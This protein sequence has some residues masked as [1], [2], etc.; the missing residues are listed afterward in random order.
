MRTTLGPLPFPDADRMVT[1]RE[2]HSNGAGRGSVSMPHFRDR[3]ATAAA[4][5]D[6]IQV[7]RRK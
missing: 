6:P 3:R 1:I 2:T 4:R 5:V 7:R